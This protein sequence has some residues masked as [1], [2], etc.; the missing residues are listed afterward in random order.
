MRAAV[1]IA[2]LLALAVMIGACTGGATPAS[3]A[4][5]PIPTATPVSTA[6][7][8]IPTATPASTASASI[9]TATT[10][11]AGS[12]S[13]STSSFIPASTPLPTPPGS[14]EAPGRKSPSIQPYSTEVGPHATIIRYGQVPEDFV[15]EIPNLETRQ[16][17]IRMKEKSMIG[18]L[19]GVTIQPFYDSYPA[20]RVPSQFEAPARY[21]IEEDH[22]ALKNNED[23]V[24]MKCEYNPVPGLGRVFH[25]FWFGST[26]S[27]ADPNRLRDRVPNHPLLTSISG[28]RIQCPASRREAE[29]IF[30]SAFRP[31]AGDWRSLA[32]GQGYIELEFRSTTET[33]DGLKDVYTFFDYNTSRGVAVKMAEGTLTV[34]ADGD[35]YM[36]TGNAGPPCPR[37]GGEVTFS[38]VGVKTELSGT[39]Y[40]L[41]RSGEKLGRSTNIRYELRW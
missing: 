33:T 39:L 34:N 1:L 12:D 36:R 41:S 24:I 7:A 8:P 37:Y 32:D 29:S 20:A 25:I 4:S 2:V 11:S 13:A 16:L 6:S 10:K 31:M 5:A 23:V 15:P 22:A 3:I 27:V 40:C 35:G 14:E 17:I 19:T 30:L 26:P 28:A 38:S 18:S 21:L 9:P